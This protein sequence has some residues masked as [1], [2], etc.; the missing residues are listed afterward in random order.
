MNSHL[1]KQTTITNPFI[2]RN[3]NP[4]PTILNK[5]SYPTTP[6][7][8]A[9]TPYTAP[10][11]PSQSNPP[12]SSSPPPYLHPKHHP[13]THQHSHLPPT[14]VDNTTPTPTAFPIAHTHQ[15]GCQP[16][17]DY[18]GKS[19]ARH[20]AFSAGRW[21]FRCLCCGARRGRLCGCGGCGLG[22]L[23]IWW[24]RLLRRRV[25]YCHGGLV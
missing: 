19:G 5:R 10:T 24:R 12:N 6:K 20:R 7:S 21:R 23:G 15:S 13:P 18:A 11:P 1:I 4:I 8:P 3:N 2:P 9:A 25:G 16:Q 14:A 17:P 22:W